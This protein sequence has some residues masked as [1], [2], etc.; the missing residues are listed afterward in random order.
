MDDITIGTPVRYTATVSME[1]ER[2]HTPFGT[3]RVARV[4]PTNA[5][6]FIV[7]RT[8]RYEGKYRHHGYDGPSE[9]IDRT[10]VHVWEVK[11]DLRKK[12]VLVPL[13]AIEVAVSK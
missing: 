12:P 8:V 7:G 10:T 1:Y 9:L 4:R 13:N 2:N 5:T 11:S 6:G 3:R